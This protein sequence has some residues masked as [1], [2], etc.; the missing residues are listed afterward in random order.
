MSAFPPP[1]A[2]HR[3]LRRQ[4]RRHLG[5]ATPDAVTDPN[6]AALV[7][8][9]NA[10]YHALDRERTL[11]GHSLDTM[12]A[13]LVERN[14]RL[15]DSAEAYRLLFERNPLPM[16]VYQP[17]TRCLLSVNDEAVAQYGWSRD[18]LLSMS[19]DDLY[20]DAHLTPLTP[21]SN[22][23]PRRKAE[24][25]HRTRDGEERWVET[26]SHA[27]IWEGAV[28]RLVLAVDVTDRRRMEAQ[29]RRQAFHDELTG[30]ANRALF[31]D[32][33]QHAVARRGRTAAP[34]TVLYLDLD[35]F[36]KVNDSLGHAAGNELLT[37]VAGRLVAAL[38]GGD[39]IARLGGDEF[40][41]LLDPLTPETAVADIAARVL[42]AVAAP[43]TIAGREARVGAS[44][45]IAA[46]RADAT[47]DDLLRDAD[48]AM[49]VAKNAGRGRVARFDPE[50][51]RR[52]VERL[53]LETDLRHAAARGELRVVYQVL[54]DL[55]TG[56][57]RGVEALVRWEH[58]RLGP[59]PPSAFVPVAEETGDIASI[60]RWVLVQ[61]CRQLRTWQAELGPAAPE[62]VSVNAS[63][64]QLEADEFVDD[65]RAALD[66]AGLAPGALTL[67]LTE[68]TIMRDAGAALGRLQALKALGVQ[69]AI[70]DF[71]TGYSSLS[72]LRQF[73]VDVLKIDKS[74]V[75]GVTSS[76]G[77]AALVRTIVGLGESLQL[78]LVAEGI[79]HPEQRA[80]LQALGCAVGQGYLLGRP[81]PA[82]HLTALL[83]AGAVAATA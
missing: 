19:L 36:K 56:A 57:V 68:S 63:G 21:A 9:V 45:G 77:S 37:R 76:S 6:V 11:V 40:A 51:H 20:P 31:L 17:A 2:L 29:L 44:I 28:A 66:E 41:V 16:F 15:S 73:P 35:G 78:H 60:G 4:L 64:R 58:P 48:A 50:M 30:L 55:A 24:R 81:A 74:F 71:G 72:Y 27:I 69:L 79:E 70:D 49:Y 43:F 54:C 22:A 46:H 1:A 25:R 80:A 12:S 13:E 42:A 5:A 61:A 52:A 7:A 75:D 10:Q 18:E 3:T 14:E 38:R 47:A 67:E 23:E 83:R 65:V 26:V 82:E 53:D 39:T 59:V 33:V 34:T 32:R 8:A 62:Y